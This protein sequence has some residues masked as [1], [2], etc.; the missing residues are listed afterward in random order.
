MVR[1]VPAMQKINSQSGNKS[2][3][4]GFTLGLSNGPFSSFNATVEEV[5]NTR[6]RL[7][8]AVS[9][10]GRSTPIELAYSQVQKI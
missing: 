2:T 3:L 1:G 9:I 10:F 6:L 8:V 7:K 4:S 5:D